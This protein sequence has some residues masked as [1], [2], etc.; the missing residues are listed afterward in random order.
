MHKGF[1]YADEAVKTIFWDA[2]YAGQDNFM[3]RAAEGYRTNRI[4]CTLEAAQA[5]CVAAQKAQEQGLYLKLF[6]AYRPQKA[7]DDFCMWAQDEG[8]TVRKAVHYPNISKNQLI[9]GGYIASKS[10]HSRGSAIDL[11]LCDRQG[12]ELDMGGIFDYMDEISWH[13]AP[14]CE[15]A[16]K[17]RETLR[18]IMLSSGFED[19]S[20]EWWHYRLKNEPYADTYFDF[21]V[22]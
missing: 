3:G 5:L 7:V 8:D 10:G 21:D 22:E 6:D 18:E 12:N 1:V 19:Y 16:A 15:A 14:V 2:K 9:S 11:T 13:G 20:K 4:I 17:N